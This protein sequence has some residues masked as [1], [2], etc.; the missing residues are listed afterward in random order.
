MDSKNLLKIARL[1][2]EVGLTQEQI[3]QQEKVSRATIS[4][5]LD[6]AVK[7]G[8]V[9]I[10]IRYPLNSV[11]YLE[12]K[13]TKKYGLKKV[14]VVPVIV[15][16]PEIIKKD[17]GGA[18]FRFLVQIVRDND[19]IGISWGMTMAAVAEQLEK[20]ER[21]GIKVV[22]LNGGI[23][24]SCFATNASSILEAFTN[25]FSAVPYSLP[26]PTIV[27]SPEIVKVI[28]GDSRIRDTL[29]LAKNSRIAIYGIGKASTNSILFKSG[30][31][32][33]DEYEELL[34]KGA[35]GDICS[36]YFNIRGEICDNYLDSRTIG[37]SLD[38]LKEKE[39]AIA[40]AVGEDK[41]KSIIGA[42]QG[43]YLNCLFTDEITANAILHYQEGG[44]NYESS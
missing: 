31:F 36:R 40:L 30:Y 3:A 28:S 21:T 24:K 32:T 5:A 16:Y 19:V 39:Y 37:I 12:E 4:R 13:I 9:E 14:F 27:D 10:K 8:I 41:A 38:L 17:V 33:P 43:G 18:L 11:E 34:N 1:Y 44:L 42:L 7:Q 6:A 20:V 15:P 35:V 29:E 23:G 22:Q 26:V 2:Y 25:A